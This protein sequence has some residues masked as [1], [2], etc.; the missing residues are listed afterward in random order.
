MPAR[1]PRLLIYTTEDIKDFGDAVLHVWQELGGDG[2][3][4]L[5]REIVGQD[6]PDHDILLI[7]FGVPYTSSHYMALK[8]H[9]ASHG[10]LCLNEPV[11]M[12][13][14]TNKCRATEYAG[15]VMRIAK[16][17]LVTR[18]TDF[19]RYLRDFTFPIV[20]KPKFSDGGKNIFF[21]KDLD[22][23]LTY[24]PD[25]ICDHRFDSTEWQVQECVDFASIVRCVYMDGKLVDAVF[26]PATEKYKIRLKLWHKSK[27]WPENGRAKLEEAC[28]K[29]SKRFNMPILVVDF[30]VLPD[31]EL[32][33]N[34]I[35][36]AT[37]LRWL[38]LRSGVQHATLLAKF[39]LK[40]W[41]ERESHQE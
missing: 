30:F 39:A 13:W 11:T 23:A 32:V 2:E 14:T 36:S 41:R 10:C 15:E 5:G 34:E 22:E 3:C 35:N 18:N 21:Y 37:N 12:A 38:R 25:E 17:G 6:L 27:V 7:R 16:S 29:L 4:R 20:M 24:M 8:A 19:A 1:V 26:D 33:F 9:V 40:A 31:G 28:A